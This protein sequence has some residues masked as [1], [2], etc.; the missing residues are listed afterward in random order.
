MSP[1]FVL[2]NLKEG[3]QKMVRTEEIIS[4]TDQ[5]EGSVLLRGSELDCQDATEEEIPL[6]DT[7]KQVLD[8]ILRGRKNA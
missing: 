5:S 3:G 6:S 4:I 1:E 2:V 8:R 7:A